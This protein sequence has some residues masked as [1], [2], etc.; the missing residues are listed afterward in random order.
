MTLPEHYTNALLAGL[1]DTMC[2]YAAD[3]AFYLRLAAGLQ[4]RAIVDL[5]CGTGLLTV[6]L[7]RTGAAVT[8]V[9][10][11]PAMLDVARHRPG[12]DS[13]RWVEGVATVIPESSADLVVMTGHV[14]QVF[15]SDESWRETLDAIAT[16]VRP[17]G[18]LAFETRNPS[19]RAWERWNPED[20]RRVLDVPT[21]LTAY[22]ISQVELW[23]EV[24]EVHEERVRFTQ[25]HRFHPGAE[26]LESHN[27]LRFRNEAAVRESVTAAGF[28]VD[29]VFG[30]WDRSPV[31]PRAPELIVIASRP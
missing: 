31:L 4:P 29:K 25:H 9:D 17:G 19:A 16:A 8:G 5:G 2:P 26:D 18:H 15:L 30:D 1:Y 22:G 12:S 3:T 23:H 10:P 21:E 27:E 14:A 20:S 13:V 11:A 7:A 24:T 6:E 28:A